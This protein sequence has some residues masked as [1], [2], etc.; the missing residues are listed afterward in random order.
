MSPA[1]FHNRLCRGLRPGQPLRLH[2]ALSCATCPDR[3]PPCGGPLRQAAARRGARGG[4]GGG[5]MAAG[6]GAGGGG[7][8]G[9]GAEG[10]WGGGGVGGGAGLW[11]R[12]WS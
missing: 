4:R 12:P 10:R 2:P 3:A 1:A 6:G 7:G 11:A 9:G 5:G 8:G